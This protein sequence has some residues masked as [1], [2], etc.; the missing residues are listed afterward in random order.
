MTTAEQK[1]LAQAS[2]AWERG[3]V[4]FILNI[5]GETV[6]FKDATNRANAQLIN[7]IAKIGWTLQSTA[8]KT[9]G[10]RVLTFTRPQIATHQS[11]DDLASRIALLSDSQRGAVRAIVDEMLG[12]A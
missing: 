9:A 3:D 1:H 7:E 5:Q 4:V 10:R 8:E 2:Q 6:W 11:N 12:P